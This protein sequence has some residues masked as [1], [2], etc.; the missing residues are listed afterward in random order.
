LI[1]K[2]KKNLR[3]AKKE[4][5]LELKNVKKGRAEISDGKEVW[6]GFIFE[7][8]TNGTG[9]KCRA[10]K[11]LEELQVLTSSFVDK[12]RQQ[13]SLID[14]SMKRTDDL[15]NNLEGAHTR[16]RILNKNMRKYVS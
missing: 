5:K 4:D 11:D 8:V 1:W 16:S 14:E 9:E 12:S 3:G 10:E 13:A 6:G 15:E 7:E 2:K